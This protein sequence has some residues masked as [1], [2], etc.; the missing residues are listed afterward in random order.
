VAVV[1]TSSVTDKTDIVTDV[2]NDAPGAT[3]SA[4]QVRRA[5]HLRATGA[6]L[7]ARGG[8]R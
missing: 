3:V 5:G 7:R 2:P 8:A 4:G 6:P 1:T